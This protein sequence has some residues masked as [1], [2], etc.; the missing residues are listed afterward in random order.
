MTR[1]ANWMALVTLTFAP[2]FARAEQSLAAA[3]S[4]Y[5]DTAPSAP[6]RWAFLLCGLPGDDEHE[7]LYAD[8]LRET[9]ITLTEHYGFPPS[10]VRFLAG[11]DEMLAAVP[12][13]TEAALA[14]RDG[15]VSG[16]NELSAAV[17]A[18]DE[19]WVIVVGHVNHRQQRVLLNLRG[20]DIS[21]DEFGEACQAIP[22]ERQLFIVTTALSGYF[23]RP[24]AKQ[25]RIVISATDVAA[26]ANET[27]YPHAL[28]R[29][30]KRF[31]QEREP[32]EPTVLD[33]HIA[34][35]RD[36]LLGYVERGHLATE[37]ALL[38]DNFDGKGTEVQLDY[39]PIEL[40][41]RLERSEPGASRLKAGADGYRSANTPLGLKVEA[42]PANDPTPAAK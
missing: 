34:V 33:L 16:L 11:S 22:A 20:P 4:A 40:G 12:Q 6:K 42:P 25:G 19:V 23:I 30:L 18:R 3:A 27:D 14:T 1:L 32:H 38:D 31:A 28:A 9:I 37:H 24:L 35:A 21:A 29:A 5:D 13:A 8:T 41:G 2:G 26:E 39:L 36:V 15:V 10:Q 7:R 17:A